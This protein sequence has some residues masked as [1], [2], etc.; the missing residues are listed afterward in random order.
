[1]ASSKLKLDSR[2]YFDRL[3]QE[4]GDPWNYESSEYEAEKY[5]A[6]LQAL[7]KQY[8]PKA[9]EIGCS[10]GVFTEKLALR[11]GNL[12]S[13]DLIPAALDRARHRCDRFA[14]V[15]FEL[16]S[17]PA[18]YPSD[19]FDLTVVSEVGYYLDR[20]DLF[21]LS[22]RVTSHAAVHGQ[23][24]LVHWLAEVS[25]YPLRGDDVHEHFLGLREWRPVSSSRAHLYRIDVLERRHAFV[26]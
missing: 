7:Q 25:G 1:M 21:R 9:F 14:H 22:N 26:G 16:M 11:C 10:I 13:V 12:L 8:Y 4:S 17:V 19:I 5:A 6:S 24:L 15:R 23:L 3:Y 20:E 18:E 2:A